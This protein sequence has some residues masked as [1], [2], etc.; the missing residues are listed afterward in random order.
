MNRYFHAASF[1]L[2]ALALSAPG[3]ADPTWWATTRAYQ[4]TAYNQ[5]GFEMRLRDD[6]RYD[7]LVFSSYN[8]F[9]SEY[10]TALYQ[11]PDTWVTFQGNS[12]IAPSS[13]YH[14]FGVAGDGPAADLHTASWTRVV[15][16]TT[17]RA[18]APIMPWTFV[19]GTLWA[20]VTIHNPDPG[21]PVY[22]SGAFYAP[23]CPPDIM[24]DVGNI[25]L[26]ANLISIPQFTGVFAP[27]E[28][29]T[30]EL[31]LASLGGVIGF[32]SAASF[33]TSPGSET[34]MAITWMGGV[35]PAP[36]ALSLLAAG[37]M[38]GV[39]RRTR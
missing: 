5:T 13:L 34:D 18:Q 21:N 29:R 1:L 19:V 39:R 36:S 33:G 22:N 23:S 3:R 37:L 24:Q 7:H 27:G 35:V 11:V 31:P 17:V 10:C 14:D 16:G 30:V 38:L 9:P 2:A 26:P 28:S 12:W 8:G 15:G 6:R 20:Q 25:P 32:Y 4:T